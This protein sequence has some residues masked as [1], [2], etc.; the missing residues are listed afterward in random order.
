[1]ACPAPVR[2]MITIPGRGV[3]VEGVVGFGAH[4]PIPGTVNLGTVESQGL[5]TFDSRDPYAQAAQQLAQ[6]HP[7]LKG[8]VETTTSRINAVDPNI[9]S[10]SGVYDGLKRFDLGMVLPRGRSPK[11]M[12]V[13]ELVATGTR[14]FD[15][16][17]SARPEFQRVRPRRLRRPP[18]RTRPRR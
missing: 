6:E 10:L 7:L 1:M 3:V 17:D 13:P 8:V 2:R 4:R 9:F 16:I 5:D 11:T 12:D 14:L 18:R 15:L